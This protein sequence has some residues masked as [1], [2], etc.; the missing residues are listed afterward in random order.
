M[1]DQEI[2]LAVEKVHMETAARFGFDNLTRNTKWGSDSF[3]R[4]QI[5]VFHARGYFQIGFSLNRHISF[6]E[7]VWLQFAP[8]I[9]VDY[10]DINRIPSFSIQEK[11]AFPDLIHQDFG[12]PEYGPFKFPINKSGISDLGEKLAYVWSEYIEP[13]AYELLDLSLLDEMINSRIDEPKKHIFNKDGLTYRRLALAKLV[14]NPMLD[15]LIEKEKSHFPEYEAVSH[16][17]GLEYFKNFPL[18][19]DKVL[20]NIKQLPSVKHLSQV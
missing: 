7:N 16:E 10:V 12:V 15:H 20:D 13:K 9:N 17:P 6:L 4:S 3:V 18:V 14:G 2:I 11:Y 1:T 5:N 19:F 8:M